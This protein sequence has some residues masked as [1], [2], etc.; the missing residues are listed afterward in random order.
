MIVRI[1]IALVLL[2][3]ALP[4]EARGIDC[5][6][7]STR[8][9]K[10]I[11]S[12]PQLLEADGELAGLYAQALGEFKGAIAAYVRLDQ[13]T[14]LSRFRQ[15]GVPGADAAWCEIGDRACILEE[16]K[17]RIQ[18]FYSGSYRYG[19][20][21][22]GP[23]G[24]K[25]LLFP[26]HGNGYALRVFDPAHL[27]DAHIATLQDQDAGM[28]DGPDF[29]V[30]RM[31]DGNGLDLPPLE[32]GVPDGCQLRMLPQALS[33]RVWQKGACGGRDY[34]GTYRRD[35][36]QTLAD[37]KGRPSLRSARTASPSATMRMAGS[38]GRHAVW[39]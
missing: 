24:R 6:K 15:I 19:G 11:C 4:A 21:Y 12:D 28:W 30:A 23:G 31:G 18:A 16:L 38:S 20:V 9:E 14:W 22:L 34:A 2:G 29:M 27:P 39:R 37:L 32:T 25:L 35:L 17:R 36:A 1:A 33:I 26:Q 7:A 13:A 10:T 8:L 5:A 3:W